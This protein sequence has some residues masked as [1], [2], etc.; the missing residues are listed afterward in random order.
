MRIS[1]SISMLAVT[2]LMV[3]ACGTDLPANDG[4]GGASV[5]CTRDTDCKGDRVCV[6]G[7][8]EALGTT[9][10]TG[11]TSSATGTSGTGGAAPCGGDADCPDDSLFCNGKPTCVTGACVSTPV[12]CGAPP[13]GCAST[14]CVEA[15]GACVPA[16]FDADGDGHG[17][18]GCPGGSLPD[19]DCDDANPDKLPGNWDGPAG[20]GHPNKCSDGVDQDC[21]GTADDGKLANGA[22][23]TCAPG[24]TQP[25]GPCNDGTS[26]C[27]QQGA[28]GACVGASPQTTACGPCGD[29]S[30][31]CGGA[32][33]GGTTNFGQPCG[34]CSGTVQ[35][36]GGCSVATPGNLNAPCGSC[37]GTINCSGGCSVSTPGNFGAACGSCGGTINCS[38]ACSV[39]TPG[40]YGSACGSCGGTVSCS[41]S[42]SIG[43]PGNFGAACNCGTIDCNAACNGNACVAQSSCTDPN[44]H[45][46]APF[47]NGTVQ[48][49]C[50]TLN[51]GG[52]NC[53]FL[54]AMPACPAG[55]VP[56]SCQG[57]V[58]AGCN[59]GLCS[60]NVYLAS[61]DPNAPACEID[62]HVGTCASSTVSAT[63][64]C[65]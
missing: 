47:A 52:T 2:G 29:G 3:A 6:D 16:P 32:C 20:D 9:G 48:K 12:D 59:G 61:A 33:V 22:T 53:G 11:S 18:V 45:T 28:W 14:A 40:N 8:C 4:G 62:I 35:C 38:G 56:I 13:A 42:C 63:L 15:S 21:S 26:T 37:G 27:S 24:A 43:T 44:A 39:S 19:D 64:Y 49:T 10:A 57:A 46:C 60:Q 7:Q 54:V 1:I 50:S 31:T 41:G 23:C 25:C 58:T 36:G 30:S 34:M 55:T 65:Q 51:C 17:K 5:G